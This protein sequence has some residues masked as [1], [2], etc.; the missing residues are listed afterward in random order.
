MNK[1]TLLFAAFAAIQL[2]NMNPLKQVQA[3]EIQQSNV[4]DTNF[5]DALTREGF[6]ETY[7]VALRKLH[8]QHPNWIFRAMTTTED[9]NSALEQEKVPGR[10]LVESSSSRLWKSTSAKVYD[11]ATGKWKGFDSSRWVQASDEVIAYHLDPRN[12]L[13]EEDIFQFIDQ[14]Y[15]DGEQSIEGVEKILKGTFMENQ[16]VETMSYAQA[17]FLAGRNNGVNPYLLASMIVNE[18][19]TKGSS[20]IISGT[21]ADYRGIYN[22]Y[23]IEAYQKNG[24]TAAKNGLTWASK[25]DSYG[26]PWNT[27]EKAI[28]G[29]AMYYANNYLSNAQTTSYLKKFDVASSNPYVHQYMTAI[30]GALKEGRRLKKA[31]EDILD[32]EITFTILVYG[33]MPNHIAK[34]PT[35]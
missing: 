18:Q 8:S 35:E 10:N 9:W 24:K 3:S 26:R 17:I 4:V 12:F 32:T 5:E 28:A 31:Y 20:S 33:N 14:E 11:I 34:L 19:G 21:D 1:K 22:Y 27:R 7:K 29:G 6:P 13:N 15:V 16:N 2:P 23:N 30:N 25:E